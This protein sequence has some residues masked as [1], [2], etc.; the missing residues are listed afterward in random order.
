MN[1]KLRIEIITLLPGLLRSYL[2]EGVLG[3]AIR[4]GL[5]EVNLVNPRDY[6]TDRHRTTDLPPYGGGAGQVMLVEPLTRTL[7][8]L[9]KCAKSRTI[10]MTP[11]GATFNDA[12]ARRLRSY[13]RLVLVCGRYEGVD[14]RFRDSCVDEDISI[15]DY[16]LAGGE[17]AALVVTEAVARYVP[18]VLGNAESAEHESFASGGLEHPH[19]A[20]PREFEGMS[21]P[22][23]LLGGDHAAITR[24]REAEAVKKTRQRRPDLL[25]PEVEPPS[26]AKKSARA[27]KKS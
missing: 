17:L 11:D 14:Q 10:F 24:W 18:G 12:T 4:E 3:R 2:E 5:I 1:C 19:Y 13:K 26:P 16:V 25:G 6:A 20:K 27:L 15:G 7:R 21:V 9:P 8:S 22:T 23:V